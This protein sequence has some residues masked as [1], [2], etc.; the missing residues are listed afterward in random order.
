MADLIKAARQYV[1]QREVPG[2]GFN[3]WIRDMWLGLPGGKW[4]WDTYGQDDSKL[5]W[6]GAFMARCCKDVG[7]PFPKQFSSA[8]AWAAWGEDAKGP[9]L[10]AVAVL[11]RDGGGHV[12]LVTGIS[13]DGKLVRLLGGNQNDGV[14]ESWF[15]LN[16]V[17]VWRQPVGA[18]L[19]APVVAKI[20]EL[21]TSEA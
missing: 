16:R 17:T 12:A 18:S 4:F 7:L 2:P 21:S 6:C 3:A 19:P 15:L 9:R 1:G 5:P 13:P 14:N 11:K 10:G 8:L 20:G